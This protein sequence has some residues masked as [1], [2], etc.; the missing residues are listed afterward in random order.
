LRCY[1]RLDASAV[2]VNDHTAFRVDWMPFAGL[3]GSGHGVGG[4]PHTLRDMQVR[5]M[6][7][8][9]SGEIRN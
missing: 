6:I 3:R 4:I 7:V 2:M 8:I 5:K 9:R 1:E